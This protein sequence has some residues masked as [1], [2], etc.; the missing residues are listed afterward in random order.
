MP[1]K[2]H[3]DDIGLLHSGAIGKSIDNRANHVMSIVLIG[4][5][6]SLPRELRYHGAETESGT[7]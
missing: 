3:P 1:T 2:A 7:C 5:E 4:Q 6:F